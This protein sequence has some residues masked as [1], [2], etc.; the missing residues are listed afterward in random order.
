MN[1]PFSPSS[2][3][4]MLFNF[5]EAFLMRS[6]GVDGAM[7]VTSNPITE[8]RVDIFRRADVA[9]LMMTCQSKGRLEDVSLTCHA[10][11]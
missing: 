6:L 3:S 2:R 10:T 11:T 9:W 4:E 1:F 5:V 8:R 7:T